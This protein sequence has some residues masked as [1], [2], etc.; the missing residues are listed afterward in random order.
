M[1]KEHKALTGHLSAAQAARGAAQRAAVQLKQENAA[2]AETQ[3]TQ[4]R[5]SHI[6]AALVH[7][8]TSY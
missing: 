2:L 8:G 5:P 6:C 3:P 4:V 7:A 1:K